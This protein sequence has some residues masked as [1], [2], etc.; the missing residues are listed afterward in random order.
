MQF[1]QP[2]VVVL[3]ANGSTIACRNVAA[4]RTS[5]LL[6]RRLHAIPAANS[7]TCPSIP[8]IETQPTITLRVGDV[9]ASGLQ[10]A[11]RQSMILYKLVID[12]TE[13]GS[14]MSNAKRAEGLHGSR[15]SRDGD[16]N[17]PRRMCGRCRRYCCW[18]YHS[19]LT[20]KFAGPERS[21]LSFDWTSVWSHLH[22]ISPAV[23][24]CTSGFAPQRNT[25][26]H[27]MCRWPGV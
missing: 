6:C 20:K 11:H 21:L 23:R 27:M 12:G 18:L 24:L 13:S 1:S 2:V 16:P 8:Y 19:L 3:G 7:G 26:N 22:E 5:E 25:N 4:Y 10:C 15:Q 9:S 14:H 17:T